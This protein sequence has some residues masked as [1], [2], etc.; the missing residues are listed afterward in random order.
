MA[1]Y[2][3]PDPRMENPG[4]F[5][6]GRKPVGNLTI[7]DSFRSAKS[8]FITTNPYPECLVT[9]P[10][11]RTNI[12]WDQTILTRRYGRNFFSFTKNDAG[13]HTKVEFLPPK[14]VTAFAIARND[15]TWG[16]G[17]K[18]LL[19]I[20]GFAMHSATGLNGL[21]GDCSFT[22]GG[23]GDYFSS[24]YA[25]VARLTYSD[26]TTDEIYLAGH[27]ESDA[28]HVIAMSYRDQTEIVLYSRN[29]ISGEELSSVTAKTKSLNSVAQPFQFAGILPN[30][31]A[32]SWGRAS[33]R[34]VDTCGFVDRAMTLAELRSF[35]SNIYSPVIP[36]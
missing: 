35:C 26:A 21:G 32:T 12:T 25:I 24:K 7:D 31:P 33:A 4:L 23:F 3:L 29:L 14:N 36:A 9:G 18:Y 20:S 8:C 34:T 19:F 27:T 11:G 28:P 16:S 22:L 17:S 10:V 6:P 13:F 30:Y 1:N 5:L 2:P 15:G